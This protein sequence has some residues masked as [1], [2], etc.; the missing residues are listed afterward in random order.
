MVTVM[1]APL[2]GLLLPHKNGGGPMRTT[3]G[4]NRTRRC[5]SCERLSI[6]GKK[7]SNVVIRVEFVNLKH[8][9]PI[10]CFLGIAILYQLKLILSLTGE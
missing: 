2:A 6:E 8:T 5:P 7:A 10:V 3:T 9:L 4:T 1:L